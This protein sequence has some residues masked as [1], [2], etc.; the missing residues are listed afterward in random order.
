MRRPR[1]ERDVQGD[2]G[3]KG[4]DCVQDESGAK[5]DKGCEGD[6]LDVLSVTFVSDEGHEMAKVY[7]VPGYGHSLQ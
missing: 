5:G 7:K 4:E 1:G 2:V 6:N 3:S